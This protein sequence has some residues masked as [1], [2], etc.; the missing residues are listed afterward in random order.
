M[1]IAV[2]VAAVLFIRVVAVAF[3]KPD[4][5]FLPLTVETPVVDTVILSACA[6]FVFCA[7]GATV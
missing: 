2:S 1:T 7:M 4:S 6:V 3:L 5:R